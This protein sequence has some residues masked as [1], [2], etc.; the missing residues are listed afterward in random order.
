MCPAAVDETTGMPLPTRKSVRQMRWFAR[1]FRAR[2]AATSAQIGVTYTL[3]DRLLAETFLAWHRAFDSQKPASRMVRRSY[4]G[5]AAGMMFHELL[6]K[7]PVTITET[8]TAQNPA[9]T[10][11]QQHPEEYLYASYCHTIRQ[12]ILGQDF[13]LDPRKSDRLDD[14]DLWRGFS[15]DIAKD[16]TAAIH[17]L[18]QIANEPVPAQLPMT[19]DPA[20]GF[21]NR[22]WKLAERH[23]QPAQTS[24]DFGLRLVSDNAPI[25]LPAATRLVLIAFEG[26]AA[27]T[28]QIDT[29]ELGNLLNEYNAKL[30]PEQTRDRF[31]GQPISA[32]MTYVAE[33]TGQLCPG[34]F[35]TK[36]DQRLIARDARELKLT[37]GLHA[38][39]R[40]LSDGGIDVGIISHGRPKRV[41]VAQNLPALAALKSIRPIHFLTPE[42]RLATVA[43]TYGHGPRSTLLLDASSTGIGMAQSAFM[44]AFGFASK[45]RIGDRNA[46]RFAGAQLVLSDL[47]SLIC[48]N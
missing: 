27:Q 45:A 32:A 28:D 43:N 38:L 15:D 11:P 14:P 36:L 46:L 40:R 42:N 3:S 26:V 18:E 13:W 9:Q 34:G 48:A 37:S 31:F 29:E 24:G 12:A 41:E 23:N 16:R 20:G 47:D 7:K 19:S 2:M 6:R 30:T 4:V 5:F 10:A 17:F 33:R 35:A 21:G 22:L 1:S 8:V 39:L 25:P 44:P